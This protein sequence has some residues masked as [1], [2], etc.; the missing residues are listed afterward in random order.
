MP[1]EQAFIERSGLYAYPKFAE[2]TPY[3]AR[4]FN[5]VVEGYVSKGEKSIKSTILGL[6]AAI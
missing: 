4:A 2:T 6:S 1:V 3:K 5:C